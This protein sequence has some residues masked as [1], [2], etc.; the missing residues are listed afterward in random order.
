[1]QRIAEYLTL[2]RH[3]A[4]VEEYHALDGAEDRLSWLMERAPEHRPVPA[5]L[6]TDDR[7]V[8]GCLSGLWLHGGVE[9]GRCWFSAK[10]ESDMVQG[11]VSFLCDLY[12]DRAPQEVIQIGDNLAHLLGI[13]RLLS[14]TRRRAVSST[15]SYIL[16]VARAHVS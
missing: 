15:V 16:A 14:T 6:T 4:L 3:Q 2:S 11:I 10:S 9:D 5:D 1:M 12:S 7:R 8:P 13:E